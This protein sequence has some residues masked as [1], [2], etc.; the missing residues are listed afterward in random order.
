MTFRFRRRLSGRRVNRQCLGLTPS[1]RRHRPCERTVT[2]GIFSF[3]AKRGTSV[4][5]FDGRLAHGRVLAPGHYTVLVTATDA[6]GT[7]LPKSL[8][9]TIVA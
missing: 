9:F 4:L 7:S 5:A 3:A 1:N 6:T 8:R 2:V